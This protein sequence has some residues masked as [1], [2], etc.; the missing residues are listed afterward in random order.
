MLFSIIV[1]SVFAASPEIHR[2]ELSLD[3]FQRAV[4][5]EYD[6]LL[7][8]AAASSPVDARGVELVV[9]NRWAR[10]CR[11][12]SRCLRSPSQLAH[13]WTTQE[14]PRVFSVAGQSM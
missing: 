4:A 5:G 11:I 10:F 2:V 13:Q 6:T 7:E 9:R 14:E 12:P 3:E 8:A 1:G